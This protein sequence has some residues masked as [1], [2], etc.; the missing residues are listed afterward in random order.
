MRSRVLIL[1]LLLVVPA[2][3]HAVTWVP[4][5][6]ERYVQATGFSLREFEDPFQVNVSNR[7]D[8]PGFEPFDEAVEAVVPRVGSAPLGTATQQ[9]SIGSSSLQASGV[10]VSRGIGFSDEVFN[11]AGGGGFSEFVFTFD[12]ATEAT[13][14][15]DI[16]L[17]AVG[18]DRFGE[19]DPMPYSRVM[20]T[21]DGVGELLD[22]R[23]GLG[24]L[25]CGFSERSGVLTPGRYTLEAIAWSNALDSLGGGTAD[26]DLAFS[27]PEPARLGLM[28]S[29]LLGLVVRRGPSRS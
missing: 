20:L 26:F 6:Q 19:S 28:A 21:L 29:L 22:L 4:V 11:T 14:S 12:L 7:E 5:A 15:L 9:S 2:A 1:L 18:V 13:Y 23:C 17:G 10:G 3:A 16:V 25:E 24:P 27:I 8:A